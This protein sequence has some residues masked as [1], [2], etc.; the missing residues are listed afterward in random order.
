M[1]ANKIP[2]NW[3][4][5]HLGT[6]ANVVTGNTPSKSHEEY[7]NGDIPWVKPGD[8]NKSSIIYEAA[9]SLSTIGGKY[10]RIIP[11]GS[12]MV[13]C[14][15]NL[16]NVAVAGRDMA[17]NQQIN[18]LVV[19]HDSLNSKYAYYWCLTL[20]PWLVENSTSTTIS[21]VNKSN[22]EK[23]PILI[24]P[25]TEQQRIVAKLDA[26]FGH[27][28]A[29]RTRLDRIPKLLKNFR[30]QV[31]TQAV[32][33]KLTE[34]WRQTAL[35][36]G[37][38]PNESNANPFVIPGTWRFKELSK[39]SNSL[40]Y[41]S[42]SKSQNDGKV[43]VL[44]MG[45]LQNGEIDWADLKFSVD[46][47][48]IEK[49][50]LKEGDVLFNRTNSP[51]LVGKTSIFRGEQKALY[52]GYL[53]KIETTKE[54]ES[55]YLNY[56]LNSHYAKKWCWEVKT[57]GVSQSNIN[58]KKLGAFLIPQPSPKE[59]AQIVKKV[60][61]LLSIADRIESQ[62]QCLKAKIDTLPQ[63]VLTKAFKGELVPQDENDEPAGEL[64]KRI[65]KMKGV[66]V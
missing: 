54:L 20:K 53:I 9:E 12:V 58:A 34:E 23:A 14:I 21:M 32:T 41:G 38:G 18:S 64:L 29:L 22:F 46:E 19:N 51:E 42:S 47:D 61:E 56:V 57:D 52:A 25:L 13:T 49:Y 39:L 26:L 28:E 3:L 2:N 24:P 37:D 40:K 60:K 63:A 35:E 66:R 27:L 48:E 7:Y 16:G 65:K 30:Q 17:T 44:R 36:K 31:L 1:T 50:L 8:I 62:Y 10:A 4:L 33:G 6:V 59:Q 5:T 15:G 11:K 43:P 45:N 55:E